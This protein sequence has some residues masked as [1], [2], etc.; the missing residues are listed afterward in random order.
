LQYLEA[1]PKPDELP[2][3]PHP[4]WISGIDSTVDGTLV[5]CCYDGVVRVYSSADVDIPVGI[6]DA[7]HK[8]P[9]KAVSVLKSLG[10]AD[11]DGKSES[12]S[13]RRKKKS[14]VSLP[15]LLLAS[16]SKDRTIRIWKFD[17][18]TN[19]ITNVA[20]GKGHSNSVDTIGTNPA[21]TKLC[22]GSWD[23]TLM[24][25]DITT[26]IANS[27][28]AEEEPVSKKRKKS[29]RKSSSKKANEPVQMVCALLYN[30]S[31]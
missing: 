11:H 17:G 27:V 10:Y 24:L 21:G 13:A 2:S 23:N 18:T 1:A 5:T 16:G 29:S 8:L 6:S 12:K 7:L 26:D 30:V 4:D 31:A 9:V 28:P 14:S 19:S 25:W 3:R 15:S 20:I 22:S